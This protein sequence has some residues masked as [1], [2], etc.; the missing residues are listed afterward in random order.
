MTAGGSG[1]ADRVPDWVWWSVPVV[2]MT[3]LYRNAFSAWFSA[4]DFAWLGL[5]RHLR[6]DGN[7]LELLFAPAA[8]GTIRPWSERGFFLLFETLFGIDPIPFRIAAFV[9]FA[10]DLTLLAWVVRRLTGS[11]LA[12]FVAAIVW[13]SNAAL[14]TAMTW[15]SAWNEVLCPMFLLWALVLFIRYAETGRSRYWW[16]QVAV[17]VF[18]FGVLEIQVVY[19]ALAL[20]WALFAV[21]PESRRRLAL[22]AAALFPVSI[23]YFVLHTLVAPLPKVGSYVVHVD[24]SIVGTLGFYVKTALLPMDWKA[25][26]NSEDLGQA[27]VIFFYVSLA[28]LLVQELRAKRYGVLVGVAWFLATISPVLILPDHLSAYYLS[29]PLAGL[30]MVFGVAF[31][32]SMARR[33]WATVAVSVYLACMA[34]VG[35]STIS[36][37]ADQTEP[38]RVL[39]EGVAAARKAHPGRAIVLDGIGS[40]L[41]V[42]SIGNGAFYPIGADDVYLTPGSEKGVSTRDGVAD[43]DNTVLE[44][45]TAI[46]AVGSG[47]AVVYVLAGDH[48]RNIS[49]MYSLSA[50]ARFPSA[51]GGAPKR[52]NPANP[53]S[54]WLLGPGWDEPSSGLNWMHGD[55]SVRIQAPV[56]PGGHLSVQGY[57]Q[58][59]QLKTGPRHLRVSADGIPVG[60]STISD[61]ETR[62]ERLFPLPDSL[63]GR[64]VMRLDLHIDPVTRQGGVEYGALFGKIAIVP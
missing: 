43:P 36:W 32:G 20:A 15:S 5:L 8:Q 61:P 42:S 47:Q 16:L 9:V 13:A 48:L 10:I 62:F 58:Q 59:V 14:A 1:R 17:Y 29:I 12:G 30:G 35:F 51:L 19:P 49:A 40:D 60:E 24:G 4:D 37:M 7:L 31:A 27:V 6:Q 63:V 22:R 53:L 18:G 28:V 33:I 44:P 55:A 25:F 64:K 23:A 26:G 39:V 54:A 46:H 11:R 34:P 38:V 56:T 52:V 50:P 21:P 41:Y 3:I 2:F 57:F 45:E